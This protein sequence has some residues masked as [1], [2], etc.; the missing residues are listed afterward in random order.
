[1]PTI[2]CARLLACLALAAS[3]TVHAQDDADPAP[4]AS[5]EDPVMLDLIP[6]A[7]PAAAEVHAP[8]RR[9]GQ[10][11]EITVTAQRR[12]STLQDTPISLEVFGEKQLELRGIAGVEDLGSNVP[13][14]VIE[15]FPSSSTTLRVT[16]RGVGVNESQVT[17]DPAVGIY[18]DGVY[19]ARSAGLALDLADIAR[20]EVLRGPQGVLYGRNST[21]G[22][23]NIVT[24]RP[25]PSAFAMEHKVTLGQRNTYAGRSMFNL[26]LDDS[27]AIKLSTL[28]R[29]SDGFM[30]NTGPG[31][32]FGDR[33]AL[34]L[35]FD[36]R[37]LAGDAMT[38]DY[39][40]DWTDMDYVNAYYQAILR[41]ETDHGVGEYIKPYGVQSTIYSRRRLD[42]LASSAPMEASEATVSGHTLNLARRFDG[43]ELKY[44]GAH[45]ELSDA[46]FPELSGGAGNPNYR[47]DTHA[48]DSAAARFENGGEP[49]PLVKPRSFQE[50][51][52][53]E[54]QLSGTAFGER[55]SFIGGLYYFTEQGGEDG[56]P[57]HHVQSSNVDPQQ[58][59]A[60]FEALPFLREL[61]QDNV[62]PRLSAYWDYLIGI[63]NQAWAAYAQFSLRPDFLDGR[64]NLTTGLRYS[65]DERYAIKDFV[66]TQY[67]EFQPAGSNTAPV[68]LPAAIAGSPDTFVGV[69]ARSRYEDVSPS[70]SLQYALSD[71]AST[72]LSYSRAYKSGGFNTRDPQISGASGRASDGTD[73]GFG[74]VEGF[75]PERVQSLELGLKSQWLDRALRLNGALFLTRIRD[76]QTNFLISGTISDTKSRN[77]GKARIGGLELEGAF[78][79]VPELALGFQYSYL[80]ARVREVIDVD[81][82]NVADLYPFN[83]APR[84]AG[85]LSADWCVTELGWATLRSYA[86]WNYIGRRQGLVI[87]E[88]RRG[89]TAIDGYGLLNARVMLDDIRFGSSGALNVALWGRNLLDEEYPLTAIDNLPHAD[90][91]V[92]WGDPRSV[93]VDLIYRYE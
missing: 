47:I 21:G 7:A 8:E 19:L 93:G 32:D 46:V 45:R 24:R 81:G 11:E 60:L 30:E 88:A 83:A 61:I 44:I 87:T 50:Q 4:P 68:P 70:A 1:L 85:V 35:R 59:N 27:F 43:L 77:A 92:T 29:T 67:I 54:L 86:S 20:M 51:W 41:P 38:V 53:H 62:P 82:N 34:G 73:Y 6:V 23:I 72:Y 64:L 31:E 28:A 66:Q 56:G 91:A 12:E 15:P 9:R 84:H 52:S 80:D 18:L 75:K 58:T 40:Y 42:R 78:V 2:H 79:P 36:A 63:D 25:D 3:A 16:I 14:L 55:L 57:V 10:L 33:R 49:T 37:W 48:Y 39:G 90:R 22:A 71:T 69:E 65:Q 26:P 17:Q 13:G 5:F 76:M 74:F 89:L